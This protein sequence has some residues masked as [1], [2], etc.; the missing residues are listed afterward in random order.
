M[1]ASVKVNFLDKNNG[2]ISS[3]DTGSVGVLGRL[4]QTGFQTRS[5]TGVVPDGARLHCGGL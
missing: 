2:Y 3:A 4:L 5:V 1:A